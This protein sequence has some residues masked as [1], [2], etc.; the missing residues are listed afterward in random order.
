[1][2][3]GLTRAKDVVVVRKLLTQAH[4]FAVL[5]QSESNI[6]HLLVSDAK[7]AI[8]SYGLT[9]EGKKQAKEVCGGPLDE[10]TRMMLLHIISYSAC[11]IVQY[12]NRAYSNSCIPLGKSLMLCTCHT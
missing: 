12:S 10:Y 6:Q 8:E 3:R 4:L 1:M 7:D 2:L 9:E 5:L 11:V